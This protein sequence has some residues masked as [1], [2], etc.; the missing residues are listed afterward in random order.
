MAHLFKNVELFPLSR[1]A[2]RYS[3]EACG[4]NVHGVLS[5]G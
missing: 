2:A 3:E 4:M 1:P 5:P